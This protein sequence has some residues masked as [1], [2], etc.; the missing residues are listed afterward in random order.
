MLPLIILAIEDESDRDFMANLFVQ[1]QKMMLQTTMAVVHNE[2]DAEDVMQTTLEKLID[3]I[4]KLR[5]FDK[6]RTAS[7]IAASCRNSSVTY[8]QKVRKVNVFSL[9]E[10]PKLEE[11][12]ISETDES[13]EAQIIRKALHQ[14]FGDVWPQLDEQYRILLEGKYILEKSDEEL[15]EDFGMRPDSVRM[16]LCR[17]RRRAKKLLVEEMPEVTELLH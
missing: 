4:E 5:T 14:R 1:Y 13:I 15:A 8:L 9:D 12:R 2:H 7:Y 11:E 10:D 17:A 3:K 6:K 16:A